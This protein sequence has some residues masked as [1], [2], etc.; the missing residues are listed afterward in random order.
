[1]ELKERPKW[2]EWY[3]CK[4][5]CANY[6]MNQNEA[7]RQFALEWGLKTKYVDKPHYCSMTDRDHKIFQD[8]EQWKKDHP[9]EKPR[10][11]KI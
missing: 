6:A 1:M 7:Q 5:W 2:Y 11:I 3:I 8:H 9:N 4:V 10:T